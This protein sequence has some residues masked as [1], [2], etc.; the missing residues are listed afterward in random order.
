MQFLVH[1]S[2]P[3]CFLFRFCLNS[4]LIYTCLLF[5]KCTIFLNS[6]CFLKILRNQEYNAAQKFIS[7]IANSIYWKAILLVWTRGF[8][9]KK[10]N[11]F[12]Y[13]HQIAPHVP[14]GFISPLVFFLYKM[15]LRA[16]FIQSAYK[17]TKQAFCDRYIFLCPKLKFVLQYKISSWTGLCMLLIWT[18][19]SSFLAKYDIYMFR[20]KKIGLLPHELL[21]QCFCLERC[22]FKLVTLWKGLWHYTLLYF[23]RNVSFCC[24]TLD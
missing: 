18:E 6:D 10:W 19:N 2:S 21:K 12:P 7:I 4:A 22:S 17:P 20:S 16:C 14:R 24:S 3:I 15:V 13:N 5:E 8:Y 23:L 11:I 1:N 9:W